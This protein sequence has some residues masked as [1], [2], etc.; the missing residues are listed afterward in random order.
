MHN[1]MSTQ[2]HRKDLE[3]STVLLPP[4]PS[5]WTVSLDQ[6]QEA[7]RSLIHQEQ[8]NRLSMCFAIGDWYNAGHLKWGSR[9]KTVAS[10][11]PQM[12]YRLVRE[13][14]YVAK[15]FPQEHRSSSLPWNLYRGLAPVPQEQRFLWLKQAESGSI[16]PDQWTAQLSAMRCERSAATSRVGGGRRS[17][18]GH[19][20][21]DLG[22]CA[23]SAAPQSRQAP[24]TAGQ[25][26]PVSHSEDGNLT[27]AC[28][29][30]GEA[31]IRPAP[32]ADGSN[33]APPRHFET[34][35]HRRTP[36]CPAGAARQSAG[37]NHK[38]VTLPHPGFTGPARNSYDDTMVIADPG[39]PGGARPPDRCHRIFVRTGARSR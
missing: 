20:A 28:Q 24:S 13:C 22:P 8:R 1:N 5:S 31:P 11:L 34:M 27:R 9:A 35:S 4:D 7:G 36:P 2:S 17:A 33:L 12:S 26:E 21:P 3:I 6:W 23:R 29:I 25:T 14:A 37:R 18:N 38:D 19:S 15:R 16:P 10:A 30:A 39:T 32:E